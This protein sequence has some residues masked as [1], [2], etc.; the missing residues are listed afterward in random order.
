MLGDAVRGKAEE[1]LVSL[2]SLEQ[3]VFCSTRPNLIAGER[4]LSSCQLC[5]GI[6]HYC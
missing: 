5:N 6:L 4:Y 2:L 1:A 3:V